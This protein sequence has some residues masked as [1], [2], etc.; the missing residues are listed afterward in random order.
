LSGL[1]WQ[2]PRLLMAESIVVQ[3]HRDGA[4]IEVHAQPRSSRAEIVGPHAG[5]LR[6]R[7][8]AAPVDGAAN[9][10][11]VSLLSTQLQIPGSDIEIIS[12][13]SGRR[14]RV[15]V[16]GLTPDQVRQRLPRT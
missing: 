8:M 9:A 2:P 1:P 4:V 12:G 15:L 11:I 7:I 6:M 5:A 10:A 3:A 16:R 13:A 14:K